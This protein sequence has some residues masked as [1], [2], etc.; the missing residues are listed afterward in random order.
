MKRLVSIAALL[1]AATPFAAGVAHAQQS[2]EAQ[3]AEAVKPLPEDLKAGATV[4]AYDA[5]TGARQV[6]RQGTNFIECQPKMADGFIRC[7]NKV[8]APR[9]D[10][11]AKL[12][13]Q[14]MKDEDVTKEIQKAT[15]DGRL[16]PAPFGTMSYRYSDDPGRIKLLWVIS[17]PNATPETVGVSTESQRDAALKGNGKPWLMLPGTPGA[18]IMIPINPG[19]GTGTK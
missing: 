17:V 3:I 1:A 10:M 8:M 16:K 9:R 13:A 14:G 5:K 15:A 7:Y 11:E 12:R 2:K 4:V 19:P 6:L 18:H